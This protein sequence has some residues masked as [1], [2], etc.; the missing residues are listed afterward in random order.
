MRIGFKNVKAESRLDAEITETELH[1]WDHMT[2]RMAEGNFQVNRL[3]QKF[4]ELMIL[5][6]QVK[7]F[8]KKKGTHFQSAFF[9]L[10][11]ILSSFSTMYY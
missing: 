4:S 9:S 6:S 10:S 1:K 7:S 3:N 8:Y 11:S 5:N 2:M